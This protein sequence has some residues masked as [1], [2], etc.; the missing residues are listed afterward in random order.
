[1]EYNEKSIKMMIYIIIFILL[2]I[3]F[4]HFLI[5][6]ELYHNIDDFVLVY[7]HIKGI[8]KGSIF[9]LLSLKSKNLKQNKIKALSTPF[10]F[11]GR[12]TLKPHNTVAGSAAAIQIVSN[13]YF[14]GSASSNN[15][16]NE[17]SIFN[18]GGG[19]AGSFVAPKEPKE[20]YAGSAL[21]QGR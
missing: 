14:T 2:L 7:N 5:S 11:G 8:K 4:V 10:T 6:Y 13:S 17:K 1:M 21:V 3:K 9:I 20:E 19:G 16:K 18:T 15:I 12:A